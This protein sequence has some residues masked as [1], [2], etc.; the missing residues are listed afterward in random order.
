MDEEG[1]AR[2]TAGR[3]EVG[4]KVR[5]WEASES[6]WRPVT[7]PRKGVAAGASPLSLVGP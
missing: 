1:R 3:E 6:C 5:G 2:G 4:K 7:L